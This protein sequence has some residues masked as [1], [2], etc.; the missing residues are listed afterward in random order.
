MKRLVCLVAALSAVGVFGCGG[1]D[2]PEPLP[3]LFEQKPECEGD[4]VAPL[5][6]QHQMVISFLEIGA[7]EDG[8][9]LD[10]DGEPDNKLA[11][12]GTLARGAIEDSF[13]DFT[14]VIPVEFFDFPTPGAD[15]CVKF[16]M[17]LGQYAL[18]GDGDGDNTADDKGD[19]N[20]NDGAINK[21][22]AEVPDNF[23]DDDC[24]GLADEIDELVSNDAGEMLVTTASDNIDDM[25]GD[26]VTIADGDCDDTNE[27]VMGPG[28]P[29]ICGDG[30]DNDC[31]GNADFAIDGEGNPVCTPYDD[32]SSPDSIELD[33]L[34]FEGG[35]PVI[36]FR[37]GTVSA[38]N[39]LTAGPSIFSV[40]IP[41]T[42]DLNLDLRISGA[43]IEADFMMMESGLGIVNGRLGGI[44]D[45]HTADT[46][47]GLEVDEI[48]LTEEDTLLDA[49]FAN[50]LGT[51][52]GLPKIQHPEFEGCQT[53]DI[54]VDR[55]GLEAFCDSDPLD[56]IN[57]VDVCIDGDGTIYRDEV[58]GSG[59][60]TL[61]CTEIK[62]ADGNFLFVDGISVEIN[63][64][65][66][67][68]VLPTE[69]P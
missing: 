17:Y 6:G 46:I 8:F 69:L 45:A 18:D 43:T 15:E 59:N 19:C 32:A 38:N 10:E 5:A 14:I 24:D 34:S 63:F 42:D 52:I 65:T 66:V 61:H 37:S 26:T 29:E 49:V 28:T 47:T 41:V 48:G 44:I 57:N 62:D 23:K 9:D 67:P 21:A 27:L 22:A 40:G 50:L 20:D 2:D 58:D 60:V 11:A 39:H 4:A 12:V 31:D 1:D 55:D 68:V 33:P 54:D 36:A 64:E 51:L 56:E 3:P 30:L 7:R 35:D 13:E 16:A 53:P 25:D